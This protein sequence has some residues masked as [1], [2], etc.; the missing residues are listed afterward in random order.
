RSWKQVRVHLREPVCSSSEHG[1]VAQ[2][3]R[4]VALQAIGQGF[5]SLRAHPGQRR[6]REAGAVLRGEQGRQRVADA[7]SL[8]SSPMTSALSVTTGGSS[9]RWTSSVVLVLLWPTS[10]AMSSRDTPFSDMSETKLWRNSRG[11]HDPSRRPPSRTLG[12]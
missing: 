8:N 6:P 2:L 9:L 1:R 10:R 12:S 3:A 7:H 5:E 11:V 4:A